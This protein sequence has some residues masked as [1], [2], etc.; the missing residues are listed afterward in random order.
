MR[1]YIALVQ[2]PA[3][4]MFVVRL[5]YLCFIRAWV[6]ERQLP[7]LDLNDA[8]SDVTEYLVD[9]RNSVR[10]EVTSSLFSAVK[11]RGSEALKSASLGPRNPDLIT[12]PDFE[13]FGLIGPVVCKV[14][15]RVT[16]L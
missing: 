10:V 15:S 5:P 3:A 7:P 6:N 9:G 1:F 11:A 16:V 13:E 4:L 14:L 12:G 2:V 8:V